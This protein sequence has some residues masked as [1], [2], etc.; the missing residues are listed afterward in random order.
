M[1]ETLVDPLIYIGPGGCP[2]CGTNLI[3]ADTEI[4]VMQLN[5]EGIPI[6]EETSNRIRAVCPNCGNKVNMVRW[7]GGYIPYSYTS[8]FVKLMEAKYEAEDRVKALNSKKNR[9]EENPLS[10]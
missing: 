1:P 4:S 6:S 9:E 10:I 3:V 2:E 7:K 8:Y 5:N